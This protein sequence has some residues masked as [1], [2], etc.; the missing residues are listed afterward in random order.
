MALFHTALLVCAVGASA[1]ASAKTRKATSRHP[2]DSRHLVFGF[3]GASERPYILAFDFHRTALARNRVTYEYKAWLARGERWEVLLDEKWT[4][5]PAAELFPARGG[6]R[7]TLGPDEALWVEGRPRQV[8]FR[9]TMESPR[10]ASRPSGSLGIAQTAHPRVTLTLEGRN[11]T[12]RAVYEWVRRP[13]SKSTAGRGQTE[14]IFG[15]FDRIVLYDETGNLWQ[16]SRGTRTGSF[17]C[18]VDSAGVPATFPEVRIQWLE[19]RKD[20]VAGRDSPTRWLLEVPAWKLR[21]R[22]ARTGEHLGH[23]PPGRDG[24]RPV[25]AQIGVSGEGSAQG[26]QRRFFGVVELIQD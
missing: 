16:A 4:G 6:V 19:T 21:A 18:R 23:G 5:A 11:I 20:A 3:L 8:A 9:I 2:S 25:Y 24:R 12:G 22:L 13:E 10:F 26:T 15:D 7:P 1:A 14:P 17:A